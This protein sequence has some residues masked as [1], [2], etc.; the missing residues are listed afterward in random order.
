MDNRWTYNWVDRLVAAGLMLGAS[1]LL[2]VAHW[3]TPS[4][5]GFGTH[6]QLGLPPCIFLT[7]THLPC[8]SCGLTTCFAWAVRGEFG[9]AFLANP[10]G[11][12][13]FGITAAMIPTALV[14]LGRRISFRRITESVHFC[15]G[16]Y[17]VTGLYL[18]NWI[19]KLAEIQFATH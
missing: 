3:L 2:F 14:L 7:L 10:F 12:V 17:V 5:A 18:L 1:G 4:A 13:A 8:P 16:L 15:K 19:V 11:L 6:T 9:K